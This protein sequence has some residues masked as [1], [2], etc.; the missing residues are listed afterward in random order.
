MSPDEP[1][2]KLLTSLIPRASAGSNILIASSMQIK[3]WKVWEISSS[4]GRQRVLRSFY[5]RSIER[6]EDS[7]FTSSVNTAYLWTDELITVG[8]CPS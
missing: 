5:V 7:V 6:L 2:G 4:V 8:L 1:A 3:R